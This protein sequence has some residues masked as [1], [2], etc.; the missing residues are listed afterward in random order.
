MMDDC[1]SGVM[2]NIEFSINCD[3]DR[4]VQFTILCFHVSILV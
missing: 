1:T 4:S 2:I 3:Y